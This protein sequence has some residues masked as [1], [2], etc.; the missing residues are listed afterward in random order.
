MALDLSLLPDGGVRFHIYLD[1]GTPEAPAHVMT[2][3]LLGEASLRFERYA[4]PVQE[5][6][7]A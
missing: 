7:H 6:A 3:E 4:R 1:G 5:V 2:A